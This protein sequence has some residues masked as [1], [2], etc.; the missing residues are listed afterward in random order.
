MCPNILDANGLQTATQQ[1]LLNI[2]TAGFQ[3]IYGPDIVLSTDSPDGQN[4][5]LFIQAILDESNLL[6]QIYNTFDPDN[7]IGVTLDQRCA[8]N[9]IQRQAGTFTIT[10]V[11]LVITSSVNLFGLDQATQPVYTV[12]DS[13]GNQWQ[14][15]TTQLGVSAG[16][17]V[18]AFQAANPGAVSTIPN[19]ITVPVTIELGVSSINNPTTYTTL[20]LNEESDAT[21][22]VRRSMS[23]SNPSQGY[24][25]GLLGTLENINGIVSAFLYENVTGSTDVDGVPG[26]SIWAIVSGTATVPLAVAWSSVISYSYGQIVSSGGIN[27]ISWI[28]NNL[29]N[30]VSE[31]AIW[32][33]YNPVAEAIYNKRNAGCGMFGGISYTVTQIDGTQFIVSWDTVTPENLFI[34]FTAFSLDGVNAPN[35]AGILA[36]LPITYVPGVFKEVNINQLSTLVQDIDPNTM[37]ITSGFSTSAGGSYTTTLTPTAKNF[38]F[39]VSSANIIILPMIMNAPNITFTIV[40]GLVTQTNATVVNGGNTIQFSGLGGYGTYTYS[41]LSGSG[42]INSSTGLYTSGSAGTDTVEVTDGLSN[43]AQC[44]ITVT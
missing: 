28:N 4:I 37:V 42:S 32:G 40:S 43:T 44:V 24:L 10:N 7:A 23:V 18:Y 17:Y 30:P 34:K 22:K 26:H 14:I 33:I 31:S 29:N 27:Y 41:L 16:T 39:V 1:E 2:F 25:A 5:N 36:T 9:G 12:A 8:I 3:A 20:G 6:T 15:I 21:L 38:Q 11:T 35:I 19:T 13:A